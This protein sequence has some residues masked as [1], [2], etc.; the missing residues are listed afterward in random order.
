MMSFSCFTIKFFFRLNATASAYTSSHS[1]PPLP[2][3]E[4][5]PK[6]CLKPPFTLKFHTIF[7]IKMLWEFIVNNIELNYQDL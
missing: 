5:L 3:P 4:S 6:H 7:K 1:F 2:F